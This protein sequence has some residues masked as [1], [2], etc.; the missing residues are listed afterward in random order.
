VHRDA[1]VAVDPVLEIERRLAVSR[2]HV[3]LHTRRL[4]AFAPGTAFFELAQVAALEPF[5]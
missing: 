3:E 1:W 5:G 4:K 2:D